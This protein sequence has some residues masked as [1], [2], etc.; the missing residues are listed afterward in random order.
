MTTARR[1]FTGGQTLVIV[2]LA[3]IPMLIMAGLVID[4][5][6]AFTRQRQVQNAMDAAA[7]AGAVVIVQNL[8]FTSRGAVGPKS[9]Q[10]VLSEF[11]ATASANGVSDP[12]PDSVYTDINGD[13]LVDSD[14]KEIVVGSL[15]PGAAPP[16]DAYGIEARGSV[17]FGTFFAGIAGFT[18]FEASARA[19]AVA[20]AI[21]DICSSEEPCAFIPVTFP[22][23]LTDCD[24]TGKQTAFGSGGPYSLVIPPDVPDISNEVIIPLC[25]TTSGS[26]GWLDIQ[27]HNPDCQGN[28]AK[29]LACNIEN[30]RRD[31]LP[32]PIWIGTR[33]GNINSTLVQTALDAYS[34]NTVGTYEPGLDKIVQI[35]LYDC[36]DNNIPQVSPGPP[37]PSPKVK[38]VGA[39]TSYHVVAVA[40]LI[41]DHSYIQTNNPECN[42]TP[43]S[44]P[45]G[46]NA[47]DGCLKGWLTQILTTGTVGLPTGTPGTVWGVQLIR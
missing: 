30:P 11:L 40:A 44:P 4:G 2:A 20:G 23:A 21:T 41:L 15:T 28:G 17:R 42:Q 24:N 3:M 27:P 46:G 16:A 31:A 12:V 22:T 36:I 33:T 34:G 9:D 7:D 10:D 19:T 47:S 5:G 25:G 37:C 18:G 13:P 32:L 29:E 38:G 6:Y 45:I 8:P 43:G 1:R 26:V 14:G 39:N 35:P